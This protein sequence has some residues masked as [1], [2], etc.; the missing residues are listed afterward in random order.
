MLQ[1]TSPIQPPSPLSTGTSAIPTTR[2]L[3]KQQ[4]PA[5]GVPL[6][7]SPSVPFSPEQQKTLDRMARET[8]LLMGLMGVLLVAALIIIMI[9]I[10]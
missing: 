9:I 2:L 10:G 7:H 3:G 1:E 6:G 5:K 8:S 4:T